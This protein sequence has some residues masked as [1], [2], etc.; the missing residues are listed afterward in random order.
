MRAH[1]DREFAAACAL[2]SPPKSSSGLANPYCCRVQWPVDVCRQARYLT[3]P[4]TTTDLVIV[5]VQL[6]PRIIFNHEDGIRPF[7]SMARIKRVSTTLTLRAG[8]GY[9]G[10]TILPDIFFAY[11]PEDYY[12]INP[13]LSYAPPGNDKLRFTLTAAI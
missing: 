8:T 12:A 1:F 3:I 4:R 11:D 2:K 10:D 9:L 6:F 7:S 5:A 13:T